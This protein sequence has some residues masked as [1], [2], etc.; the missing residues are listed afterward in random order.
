MARGTRDPGPPPSRR[1]TKGER[2]RTRILDAAEAG[3]A[4]RGFDG[5]SLREI[6]AE[7][8]I[9]EPGLYNYFAGKRALYAA[10]LDRALQPMAD[11]LEAAH[12]IP[13]ASLPGRMMDLLAEHP[14]LPAFFQQAL[15]GQ[16]GEA[17]PLVDAWLD[18]LFAQGLAAAPPAGASGE[19]RSEAAIRVLAMFH[20]VTGYFLSERAFSRMAEGRL[21]DPENLARQKKLLARVA[22][23]MGRGGA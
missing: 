6:A 5:V 3:F 15:Q 19:D 11:A 8:G 13:A 18:R 1:G 23:A 4:E 20:L 12:T 14:R 16:A 10:V 22:R 9:R 21:L 7:A 2:T 17:A